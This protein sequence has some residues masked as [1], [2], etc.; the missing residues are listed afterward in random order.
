MNSCVEILCCFVKD[1]AE[2]RYTIEITEVAGSGVFEIILAIIL[3][4]VTGGGQ[5]HPE[6]LVSFVGCALRTIKACYP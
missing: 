2:A 4:A 5:Y 3:V 6:K 1:Y